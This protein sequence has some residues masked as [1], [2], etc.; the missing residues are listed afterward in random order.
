MEIYSLHSFDIFL[1]GFFLLTCITLGVYI[2]FKD[3]IE[4]LK[5]K[6]TLAEF[7]KW[8]YE[9]FE[10][11]LGIFNKSNAKIQLSFKYFGLIPVIIILSFIIGILGKGVADEWID[12]KGS[13]HLYLKSTWSRD[14]LKNEKYLSK[15]IQFDYKD[16]ISTI[17]LDKL[18]YKNLARQIAFEKVF[19][20][21][22]D[23]LEINKKRIVNQL[24]YQAKHELLSISNEYNYVRK[25]Q[26]MAEYSRIFALGFFILMTCG[27]LNLMIMIIRIFA[28]KVMLITL[29]EGVV[30]TDDNGTKRQRAFARGMNNAWKGVKGF[31]NIPN[32]VIII[33]ILFSWLLIETYIN[34]Y[35]KIYEPVSSNYLT[36]SLLTYL[37][38]LVFFFFPFSKNFKALKFSFF[39]YS[40]IY[41]LSYA[42]Y[43]TSSRN[44]LQSEM[45]VSNKIYGLYKSRHL[46][47]KVEEM[48]FASKVLKLDTK[49][50]DKEKKQSKPEKQPKKK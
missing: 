10:K 8:L 17:K 32:S 16:T 34:P 5:N 19:G 7:S 22:L 25:S 40:T 37:G 35:F 2:V 3:N 28:S 24:Y 42:G 23:T 38:I 50:L 33:M 44:W 47:N 6:K 20:L 4:V 39:I 18:S 31:V 15:K 11:I 30:K 14:F 9:L 41:T 29:E 46:T 36:I 49:Y 45:K 21:D 13:S 26:S 1:Q 27:F 43:F 12:A 48:I